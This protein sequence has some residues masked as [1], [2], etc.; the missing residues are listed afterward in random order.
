MGRN[1]VGDLTVLYL[2]S[3]E[4]MKDVSELRKYQI[5]GHLNTAKVN[6]IIHFN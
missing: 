3:F 2:K 1:D 4:R 6:G 5:E